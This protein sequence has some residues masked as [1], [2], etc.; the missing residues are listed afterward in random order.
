MELGSTLATR[1]WEIRIGSSCL[2][3]P[4]L[5]FLGEVRK[6]NLDDSISALVSLVPPY[7]KITIL[8]YLSVRFLLLEP[9]WL[10]S[11]LGSQRCW[12][13]WWCS[14]ASHA[15]SVLL[16]GGCR[17]RCPPL[18]FEPREL[19]LRGG[20]EVMGGGREAD[21]QRVKKAPKLLC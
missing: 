4:S 9:W 3:L 13:K 21:K 12:S 14:R 11:V 15:G 8:W 7:P 19:G 16:P 2:I 5:K 18:A 20:V 17:S 6:C 1:N 10:S